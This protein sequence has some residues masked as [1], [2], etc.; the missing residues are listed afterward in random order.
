MYI[1]SVLINIGILHI[2]DL[3]LKLYAFIFFFYVSYFPYEGGKTVPGLC[4]GLADRNL[5][6]QNLGGLGP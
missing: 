2:P 5:G 1:Y 4:I 3:I 6:P